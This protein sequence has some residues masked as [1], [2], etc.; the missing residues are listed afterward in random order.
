M[1]GSVAIYVS[2]KLQTPNSLGDPVLCNFGSSVQGDMEHSEDVQLDVY[3]TPEVIPEAPRPY[4]IKVWNT[5]CMVSSGS[6]IR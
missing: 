1:D 5:G 2:R 6:T 4:Q 3:R